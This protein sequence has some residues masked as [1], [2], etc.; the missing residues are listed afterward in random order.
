[1]PNYDEDFIPL[2]RLEDLTTDDLWDDCLILRPHSKII[3][4]NDGQDAVVRISGEKKVFTATRLREALV[5]L[6][7][8]L[9]DHGERAQV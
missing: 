2:D 7:I 6:W 3:A 5:R 9:K 8:Y 4:T 1:M